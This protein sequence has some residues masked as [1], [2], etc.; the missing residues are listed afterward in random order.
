MN[1]YYTKYQKGLAEVL[2]FYKRVTQQFPEN[3]EWFLKAGIF[4]FSFAQ[5]EPERYWDDTKVIDPFTGEVSYAYLQR[6]DTKI[7]DP[8]LPRIIPYG[9]EIKYR[10]TKVRLTPFTDGIYYLKKSLAT[11][12]FDEKLLA[13][14][15]AK[16]GD[17]HA[18]QGLSDSAV[19]F[20][21]ASIELNADD[22]G[23]RNKLVEILS[24]T[25]RFTEALVQLDSLSN[26]NE[27]NFDKELML[28]KYKLQ[29]GQIAEAE[30]LLLKAEKINPAFSLE[31][32]SLK[33]AL[34]EKKGNIKQA[35]EIY[36]SIYQID[37]KDSINLY[38]IS[39]IYSLMGNNSEAWKWLDMS[40]Q[41]GF[42]YKTVL[43]YDPALKSLRKEAV[44]N[45]R[46]KN[47][48]S[49]EYFLSDFT[50]WNEMFSG[51]T[52]NPASSFK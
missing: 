9:T 31:L 36:K 48:K 44:W 2:N 37:K 52:E 19:Y 10:D 17:L 22:A 23:I 42:N 3:G 8:Q 32:T 51:L 15:N 14:I 35:L 46:F 45:V 7:P 1:N 40:L 25:Y 20:Y 29:D 27:L 33:A 50:K 21:Q 39:R 26:R 16:I 43:Q 49:K 24:K 18:W 11:I 41:Q 13:G 4:Q 38:N 28:V 47:F 34:A 12:P 5:K 30:K 6:R